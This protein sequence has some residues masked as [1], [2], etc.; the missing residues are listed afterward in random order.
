M[1][2]NET[3]LRRQVR[4]WRAQA[5]D[6]DANAEECR[7]LIEILRRRGAEDRLEMEALLGI[8]RYHRVQS[9]KKSALALG[10]QDQLGA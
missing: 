5:R 3:T 6:H 4:Q 7:R 10:A 9:L 1:K 2:A 8:A